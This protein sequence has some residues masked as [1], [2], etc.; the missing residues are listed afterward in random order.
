MVATGHARGSR[1]PSQ[2]V[3]RRLT[4]LQPATGTHT[5]LV[6]NTASSAM[7]VAIQAHPTPVLSKQ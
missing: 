4:G 7:L 3:S 6:E 5:A 1:S 2:Q